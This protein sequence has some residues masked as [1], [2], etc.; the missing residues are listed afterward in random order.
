MR[1]GEVEVTLAGVGSLVRGWEAA[2][3]V[4]EVSGRH[5]VWL[6]RLRGYSVQ[7][8]TARDVAALAERRGLRV[9]LV[10]AVHT[11]GTLYAEGDALPPTPLAAEVP[12]S[13]R[14]PADASDGVDVVTDQ[15]SLW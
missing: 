8:G 9:L 15:A 10:E 3:L 11:V 2:G 6:S 5:P 7:E 12:H 13:V 4:R 14:T 1:A